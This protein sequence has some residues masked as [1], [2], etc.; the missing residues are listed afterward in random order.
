[1]YI[2]DIILDA[3]ILIQCDIVY[4]IMKIIKVTTTKIKRSPPP[5]RHNLCCFCII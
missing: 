2:Y 4:E 1:M 3:S 5:S